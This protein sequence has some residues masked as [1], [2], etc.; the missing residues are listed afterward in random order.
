VRRG[1]NG[2]TTLAVGEE[3]VSLRPDE[4]ERLLE[5]L[6]RLKQR[7]ADAVREQIGAL[8]LLGSTIRLSPAEAQLSTLKTALAS[9]AD[10]PLEPQRTCGVTGNADGTAAGGPRR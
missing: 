8:R 7:D 10:E 2:S 3:I 6:A 1:D 4:L 5:A 9:L